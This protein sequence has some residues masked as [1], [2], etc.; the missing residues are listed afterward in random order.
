MDGLTISVVPGD[1]GKPTVRLEK[2]VVRQG[3]CRW[4]NPVFE[5]VKFVRE[6]KSGKINQK[7]YH[8]IVSTVRRELW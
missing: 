7:I 6:P 4:E 3:C 2:A 5:T 8:F 1:V